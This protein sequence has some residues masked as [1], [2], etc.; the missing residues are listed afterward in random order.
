MTRKETLIILTKYGELLELKKANPHDLVVCGQIMLAESFIVD[1]GIG[2]SRITINKHL[3]K[4]VN[5]KVNEMQ[6]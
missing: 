5:N 1:L 3:L 2:G 6:N 4:D